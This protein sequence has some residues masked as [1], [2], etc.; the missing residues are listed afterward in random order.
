MFPQT[1]KSWCDYRA[2]HQNRSYQPTLAGREICR[3]HLHKHLTRPSPPRYKKLIPFFFSSFFFTQYMKNF[4]NFILIRAL[5][6][7][8]IKNISFMSGGSLSKGGWKPEI[9]ERLRRGGGPWPRI[10]YSQNIYSLCLFRFSPNYVGLV[11]CLY[12]CLD[13]AT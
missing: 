9:L 11:F 12:R 2:L 8:T 7:G 6:Y 5:F 1:N 3:M 13:K 10:C 4:I